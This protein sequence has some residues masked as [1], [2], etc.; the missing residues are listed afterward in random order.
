MNCGLDRCDLRVVNLQIV[1]DDAILSLF[2][3]IRNFTDC[4]WYALSISRRAR[5]RASTLLDIP[6]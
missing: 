5:I 3:V 2:H 6:R 4:L 1:A